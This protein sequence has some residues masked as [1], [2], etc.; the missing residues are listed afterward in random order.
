MVYCEK[1]DLHEMPTVVDPSFVDNVWGGTNLDDVLIYR[2]GTDVI[3]GG[4]GYDVL[5]LPYRS[6]DSVTGAYLNSNISITVP[7]YFR[8]DVGQTSTI[9]AL[10]IEQ[11]QFTDK[12]VSLVEAE[13]PSSTS[14]DEGTDGGSSSGAATNGQITIPWGS[15]GFWT[16]NKR[17]GASNDWWKWKGGK[18]NK[19]Y[20]M[21]N[22]VVT[23]NSQEIGNTPLAL[24]GGNWGNTARMETWGGTMLYSGKNVI[25][26][27]EDWSTA[28]FDSA[29]KI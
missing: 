12:A 24:S 17:A 18:R 16:R 28:Q 13:A 1:S 6:V 22:D 5:N 9:T 19:K 20:L 3:N 7:H 10:N 4:G 11:I 14:V 8:S 15:G 29:T 27:F 2:G 21:D 26:F 23:Y 25:A